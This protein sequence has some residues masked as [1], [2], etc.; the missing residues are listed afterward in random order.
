MTADRPEAKI[1]YTGK[2]DNFSCLCE[3]INGKPPAWTS[4][5]KGGKRIKSPEYLRNKLSKVDIE[6]GGEGVYYCFALSGN[7]SA[8]ENITL[9][10]YNYFNQ[11]IRDLYCTICDL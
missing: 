6:N 9:S 4:W 3:G 11:I 10:E 8:V 7:L 1:S 5:F 2:G